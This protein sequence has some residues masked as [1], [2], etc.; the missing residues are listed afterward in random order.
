MSQQLTVLEMAAEQNAEDKEYRDW[1][2]TFLDPARLEEKQLEDPD[3][4]PQSM[5]EVEKWYKDFL[6]RLYRHI[7]F[8][9]APELS[10]TSWHN[11]KI[12]FIFSVPTTW[13]PSTV[14]RF[15]VITNE[16]GFGSAWNHTTSI[17]LTEAEAAAVHTSTGEPGIFNVGALIFA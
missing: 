9:L 15:R 6:T 5:D 3:D 12:E 14:E 17:G 8:K 10:R 11:A 7:E 1:F 16:A 4:A 13:K 2:K